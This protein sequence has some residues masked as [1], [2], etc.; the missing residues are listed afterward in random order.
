MASFLDTLF[1][2]GAEKEAAQKD[3]AAANQY[4]TTAN[5]AL[6]QGYTTGS[7][8]IN[9]AVGAYT[10]LANLGATYSAGA[11]AYM[12]ALGVGS[13]ADVAAARTNFTSTPG[14]QA[15]LDSTSQ[16][17]ARQQAA[18]GMSNSG[19]ADINA[20]LAGA[21]ITSQQYQQYIQNLQQAGSM[22]LQA[23]GA[24]AQGQA[25]GYGSLAN[26]ATQYGEDQSGVAGNVES[27]TVG[28]NNLAAAGEAAG[29][30]NLLGA[31]LSLATL[32]LGGNPFGGSLTGGGGSGGSSLLSSLGTGIKN[33]NLGQSMFGGGSPTGY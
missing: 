30:K 5:T 12:A 21:G 4:G 19:N 23:T 13:P 9:S 11:P 32:G 18:G 31:G 16:A 17:V 15:L 33:L 7:Q 24:A 10:P 3:I 22:G 2:G 6:G 26:L 27:T 25:A 14:Y 8:A 20:I 1:G 28:S 29:A